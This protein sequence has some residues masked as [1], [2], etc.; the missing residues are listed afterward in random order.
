[1]PEYSPNWEAICAGFIAKLRTVAGLAQAYDRYPDNPISKL[2]LP[3]AVVTEPTFAPSGFTFGAVTVTYE[4]TL[5][6]AVLAVSTGQAEISKADA[7]QCRSL[8]LNVQVYF[9]QHRSISVQD[10]TVKISL[11]QAKVVRLSPVAGGDYAG[12]EIPYSLS[13]QYASN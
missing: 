13:I 2:D 12:L 1:M 7:N 11:G 10:K 9:Q 5:D 8:G 3:A 6:I 4:G